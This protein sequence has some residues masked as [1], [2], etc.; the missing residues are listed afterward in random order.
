MNFIVL[1]PAISH[2][3]YKFTK[4]IH[5]TQ[6]NTEKKGRFTVKQGVFG[7]KKIQADNVYCLSA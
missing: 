5:S 1:I 7:V 2:F 4:F 6:H 3:A